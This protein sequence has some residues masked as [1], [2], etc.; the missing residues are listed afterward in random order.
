ML[1]AKYFLLFQ[2]VKNESTRK[3][4]NAY[5]D[6]FLTTAPK[7]DEP[8]YC[9]KNVATPK[10]TNFNYQLGVHTNLRSVDPICTAYSVSF[11]CFH[12]GMECM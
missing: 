3:G 4:N 5:L 6:I 1:N 11:L 7:S 12:D 2:K 9:S 10:A 8:Q